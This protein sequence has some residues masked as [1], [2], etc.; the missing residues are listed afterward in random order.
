MQL[1]AKLFTT[2]SHT[3]VE[4]GSDLVVYDDWADMHCTCASTPSFRNRHSSRYGVCGLES[5]KVTIA[6]GLQP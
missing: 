4:D 5:K 3:S 1:C 2:Y 6:D